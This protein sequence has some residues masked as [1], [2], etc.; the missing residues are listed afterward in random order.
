MS[1]T[2]LDTDDTSVY[3]VHLQQN[4][5]ICEQDYQWIC[6]YTQSTFVQTAE[7]YQ[8]IST[9]SSSVSR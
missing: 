1:A 2:S 7:S 3:P 8:Y 9:D 6:V 4:V 5:N